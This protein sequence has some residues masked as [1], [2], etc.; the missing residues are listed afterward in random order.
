MKP[1]SDMYVL[2]LYV[3]YVTEQLCDI[4]GH[5]AGYICRCLG[6]HSP[7]TLEHKNTIQMI[8]YRPKKVHMHSFMNM[9]A[10]LHP[11]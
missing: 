10:K 6:E 11:L 8:Q 9:H 2:I 3:T 4:L 1:L 7:N 5:E